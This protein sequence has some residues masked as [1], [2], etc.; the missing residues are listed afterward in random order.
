[1]ACGCYFHLKY[2]DADNMRGKVHNSERLM[3]LNL[4]CI[5]DVK[6]ALPFCNWWKGDFLVICTYI[7]QIGLQIICAGWSFGP[8]IVHRSPTVKGPHCRC[9]RSSCI[10][11]T[12]KN[13]QL[14][15]K[16]NNQL[17]TWQATLKMS[18]VFLHL[19]KKHFV[20]LLHNINNTKQTEIC[21][22]NFEL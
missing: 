19:Q 11:N 1:M 10:C 22:N 3:A 9:A 18:K 2:L 16:K 7:S 15:K 12:I 17:T 21:N 5:A 4:W 8:S 20:N 14:W 6:E 13:V